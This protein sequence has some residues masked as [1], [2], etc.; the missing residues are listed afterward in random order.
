VVGYGFGTGYR[1]FLE[2]G[3]YKQPLTKFNTKEKVLELIFKYPT[4]GF[5]LREISRGVKISTPMVSR[6]IKE[7]EKREIVKVKR[8]KMCLKYMVISKMRSSESLKE[9]TI[10]FH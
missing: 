2:K 9:S 5:T 10:S 3:F 1:H 4:P 8:E 7:L 6:I